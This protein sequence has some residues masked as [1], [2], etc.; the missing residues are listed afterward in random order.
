MREMCLTAFGE[1]PAKQSQDNK[2]LTHERFV[3]TAS[4]GYGLWSQPPLR[5]R[6]GMEVSATWPSLA[7]LS[8]APSIPARPFGLGWRFDRTPTGSA[9][10]TRRAPAPVVDQPAK[11][12]PRYQKLS[13]AATSKLA[14]FC[15]A[16]YGDRSR[17]ALDRAA[18][19][20]R[21]FTSP[22]APPTRAG[23]FA[24]L[25]PSAAYVSPI[26]TNTFST[27]TPNTPGREG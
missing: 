10:L 2:P 18:V 22:G 24:H 5:S 19:F 15:K 23:A 26:F 6:R 16:V 14:L 7:R 4:V 21:D 17:R 1:V 13:G 20:A 12:G 8:P 9:N 27:L 11:A 3:R 25:A